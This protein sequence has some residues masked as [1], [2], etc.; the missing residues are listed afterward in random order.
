LASTLCIRS[1]LNARSLDPGFEVK[2]RVRASLNLS[3]F[4]YSP[5]ASRDF[6]TRLLSRVQ[7]MPEVRS[8]AWTGFLPLSTEHSNGTFELDGQ[9]PGA[10]RSGF[11]EQFSV[12]PGCF[13]AMGTALLQGRDFTDSG[14][15]E[16]ASSGDHQ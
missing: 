3:D 12:G 11:F 8:A 2:D 9:E 5:A 4:G 10:G 13:T 14:S 7:S 6:Y 16:R 1:L 15:R